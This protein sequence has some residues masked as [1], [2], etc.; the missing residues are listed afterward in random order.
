MAEPVTL[1]REEIYDLVWAEPVSR[2]AKRYGLTDYKWRQ[3]CVRMSIPVPRDQYWR[4]IK[5]GELPELP[6]LPKNFTGDRTITLT[7]NKNNA[8]AGSAAERQSDASPRKVRSTPEDPLVT[9]ARYQLQQADKRWL[10]NG[11]VWTKGKYF[12][13]GIAPAN[14]ERACRFVSA[15][16]GAVQRRGYRVT[17]EEK[18]TLLHLGYQPLPVHVRE[19]TRRVSTAERRNSW[20]TPPLLPSGD[21]YFHMTYQFKERDWKIGDGAMPDEA[22]EMVTRLEAASQRVDEYYRNLERIWAENDARRK[23]EQNRQERRDSELKGFKKLLHSA[24]RWQQ[25]E[26]IRNYLT[27]METRE[28]A[29][30][31]TGLPPDRTAWFAWARAKAD[32]YDPLTETPD[33]WLAHVERNTLEDKKTYGAF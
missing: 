22:E 30:S 28:T 15:F 33:E 14:I 11:L 25:A 2:L 27:A 16:L 29:A 13:I 10:D 24:T 18:D 9:S 20:T 31:P 26:Y 21:L 5:M 3:L 32:W 23:V 8:I 4:K 1:S 12:R 6:P 19:R 17:V 7:V